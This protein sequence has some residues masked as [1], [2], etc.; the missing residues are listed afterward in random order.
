MNVGCLYC[1]RSNDAPVRIK[2]RNAVW[3]YMV[4]YLCTH[5]C[6]SV[7]VCVCVHQVKLDCR[8]V[9]NMC[10]AFVGTHTHTHAG[11]CRKMQIHM[12]IDKT[13]AYV[14]VLKQTPFVVVGVYTKQAKVTAWGAG[15]AGQRNCQGRIG[16]G[17][18][19]HRDREEWRGGRGQATGVR[20][21]RQKL[22]QRTEHE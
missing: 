12:Q 1:C 2:K 17:L 19:R 18:M 9:C 14:C 8:H 7:C 3:V 10:L 22:R 13:N 5:V 6:K 11:R 21:Q 16:T 15:T 4:L 20:A